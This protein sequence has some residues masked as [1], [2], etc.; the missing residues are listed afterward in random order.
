MSPSVGRPP[1]GP[2]RRHRRTPLPVRTPH[3]PEPQP[4]TLAPAERATPRSPLNRPD[5]VDKAPAAVHREPLDEGAHVASVSTAYRTLR[6]HGEAR[7]RRRQATH[8]PRVP[9]EPVATSANRVRPGDIT[10]LAGPAKR[11]HLHPCAIIYIYSC[12]VVGRLLADRGSRVPAEKLLAGA[13]TERRIDRH[14]LTAT[15][16]TAPRR[17]PN[18]WRSR[19]PTPASRKAAHDRGPRTTTRRAKRVAER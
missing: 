1:A 16:A 4:R 3:G 17:P 2:Y 15:P 7:E 8:P 6:E 5:H 11:S 9:P 19:S 13:T 18:R 14:T 10:K 12:N